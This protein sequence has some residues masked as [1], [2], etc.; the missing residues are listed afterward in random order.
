M[1]YVV[2]V[3]CVVVALETALL[4]RGFLAER[5]VQAAEPVSEPGK[6]V[7]VEVRSVY[8]DLRVR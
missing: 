5:P 4:V 7:P 3:L 8:S 1:K 2:A 6:V